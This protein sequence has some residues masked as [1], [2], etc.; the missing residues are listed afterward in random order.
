MV[1]LYVGDVEID[2][3]V[4]EMW[5]IVSCAP[6]RAHNHVQKKADRLPR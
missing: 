3:A 6:R 2:K 5:D 1:A 4:F